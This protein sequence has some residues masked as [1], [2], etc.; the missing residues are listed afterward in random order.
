[1]DLLTKAIEWLKL[2]TYQLFWLLLFSSVVLSLLGFAPEE[3]LEALSLRDIRAEHRTFIGL[4]WIISLSGLTVTGGKAA[5]EWIKAGITSRRRV[6]RLQQRL[7]QFTPPERA[8]L[9][10]YFTENT[11]TQYLSLRDGVARGLVAERILFCPHNSRGD[12]RAFLTTFSLGR[13]NI[14]RNTPSSLRIRAG[15]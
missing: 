7:H 1:M 9:K 10:K 3:T 6:N 5:F 15:H 11:R 14:S 2:S 13:G 12:E 4:S 8:I